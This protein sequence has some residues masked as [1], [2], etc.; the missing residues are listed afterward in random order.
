MRRPFLTLLAITLIAAGLFAFRQWEEHRIEQ[1]QQR[2]GRLLTVGLLEAVP[3]GWQGDQAAAA[4]DVD[5]AAANATR[6]VGRGDAGFAAADRTT[7]G[8]ATSAEAAAFYRRAAERDGWTV[9]DVVRRPGAAPD[10]LQAE[11]DLWG[12]SVYLRVMTAGTGQ[13]TVLVTE[14]AD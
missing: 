4:C 5:R 7:T 12:D 11:K 3:A 9:A 8:E 6:N 2:S 1:C 13:Y 10:V 14:S